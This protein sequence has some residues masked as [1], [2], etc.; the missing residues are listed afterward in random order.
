MGKRQ[1]KYDGEIE[2]VRV[3]V[4]ATRSEY[5]ALVGDGEI[6]DPEAPVWVFPKMLGVGAAAHQ[7]V[8]NS[9]SES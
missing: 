2:G 8:L 3:R 4:Y 6:D 1:P 5:E 7:A 9:K